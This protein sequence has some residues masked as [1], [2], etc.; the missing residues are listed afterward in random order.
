LVDVLGPALN[1]LERTYPQPIHRQFT[2][3][4]PVPN[5]REQ[6]IVTG[7]D[8]LTLQ[9]VGEGAEYPRVNERSIGVEIETTAIKV[10]GL[11]MSLTRE[12][13]TNDSASRFFASAANALL[14]AAYRHETGSVYSALESNPNLAD[15]QP[16]FDASNST[17]KANVYHALETGFTLFA[18]QKFASGEY[19]DAQPAILVLPPDWSM[20]LGATLSDILVNIAA[21]GLRV[22]KSGRITSAYLFANPSECPS[23]G[24]AGF[25]DIRPAVE[26]NNRIKL[27]SNAGA[28]LKV[29]H[30]FAAVPLSRLG[31]VKMS[32][33]P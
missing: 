3:L 19:V 18:G 26:L 8:G 1:V 11:I 33:T 25:G 9:Q 6:A 20:E 27:S 15:G 30:E 7:L 4:V 22:L 5:F 13:M 21:N 31:V 24:L 29:R 23:L 12:T 10:F 2:Q 14:A 17:T 32:V 28:E 16:W